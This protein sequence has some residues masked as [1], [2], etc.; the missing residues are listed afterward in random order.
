[1]PNS[2]V[3]CLPI[4]A[5]VVDQDAQGNPLT[6]ISSNIAPNHIE[7]R[8]KPDNTNPVALVSEADGGTGGFA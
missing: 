7:L 6:I 3:N 2:L 4:E 1:M 5:V 8:I